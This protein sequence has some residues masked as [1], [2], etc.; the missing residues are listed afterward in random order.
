MSA[1]INNFY[2]S[3]FYN[4]GTGQAHS[5]NELAETVFAACGNNINIEYVDMPKE[6]QLKYQYY[7]EADI[8]KLRSI[9]YNKEFMDIKKGI[10]DY[11]LDLS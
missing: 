5:F 8:S 10:A 11:I 7:T 3:G 4:I 2:P 9:G 1:T 6:L